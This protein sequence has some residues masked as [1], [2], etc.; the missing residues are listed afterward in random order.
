MKNNL[1]PLYSLNAFEAA[2]RLSSFKE[3]ALELNKTPAAIAHQIKNLEA[4]L[5]ITLFT[6]KHNGVSLNSAGIA[7]YKIVSSVIRDLNRETRKF[8]TYHNNRMFRVAALNIVANRLLRP[9]IQ[10]F[11]ADRPEIKAEIIAYSSPTEFGSQDEDVNLWYGD[12]PP[13]DH[14]FQPVMEEMLAPVCSPSYLAHWGGRLAFDDLVNCRAL[15][16][17]HWDMDWTIWCRAFN[18]VEPPNS[19]GFSLYGGMIRA[20]EDGS[21]VAI[22]HTGLIAD[23]LKSG[24]LVKPFAL[25]T[26]NPN[27]YFALTKDEKLSDPQVYAFWTWLAER[28]T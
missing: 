1:P 24:R 26:P 12:V 27:K 11:L 17:L 6:R 8:K 18:L 25:E 15:Y 7:Y 14:R 9:L 4:S 2:A 19:L 3:A 22:G 20:A 5:N 21:G 13:R 10:E 16:D 23:E 28:L